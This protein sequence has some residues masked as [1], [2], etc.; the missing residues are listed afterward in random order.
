MASGHAG[1]SRVG[2][3]YKH[4][5]LKQRAGSRKKF[6]VGYLQLI[7]VGRLT[8]SKRSDLSSSNR[9]LPFHMPLSNLEIDQSALRLHQP[10]RGQLLASDWLADS[11]PRWRLQGFKGQSSRCDI[12]ATAVAK[13]LRFGSPGRQGNGECGSGLPKSR[14]SPAGTSDQIGCDFAIQHLSI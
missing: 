9:N 14:R 2:N 12:S 4:I 3:T 11:D 8:D 5:K 13:G 6:G 7:E 10:T 1:T